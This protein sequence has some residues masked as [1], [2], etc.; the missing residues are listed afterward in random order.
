MHWASAPT[1]A[2]MCDT[3]MPRQPRADMQ[4]AVESEMA[5]CSLRSRCCVSGLSRVCAHHVA[6]FDDRHPFCFPLVLN[7]MH[8]R[9]FGHFAFAS[10][11]M[12]TGLGSFKFFD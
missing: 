7:I 11:I 10:L 9:S 3:P 5:L 2:A 12:V 4:S 8:F 6:G 1:D